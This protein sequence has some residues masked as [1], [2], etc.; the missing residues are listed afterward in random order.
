MNFL[1]SFRPHAIPSLMHALKL[2]GPE[3]Q[4]LIQKAFPNADPDRMPKVTD[5]APGRLR[6]VTPFQPEMLRPGGVIAG[7]TLMSLADTVAYAIVLAHIGEQLMA[8]TST[9]TMH[10]LR[11]AQPGDLVADAGLL[12]LG[13]RSAVCD[14]RIWTESPDALAAH[15]TVAYALPAA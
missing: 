6:M 7:P 11:G 10:F 4:A 12:R 9:L 14:V 8:V 13:A 3:V 2:T 1:S 15:A 5:A